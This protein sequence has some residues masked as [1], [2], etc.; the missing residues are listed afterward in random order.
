MDG[1]VVFCFPHAGGGSHQYLSWQ[2]EFPDGMRWVAIDRAG[3]YSRSGELPKERFEHLVKDLVEQLL[4]EIPKGQ[5]ALFGH[6]MGGALAFEV[7]RELESRGFAPTCLFVSSTVAPPDRDEHGFRFF[8]MEDEQFID[9]LLSLSDEGESSNREVL[10][11][12]L[13][14]IRDEY[15]Q[16]HRYNPDRNVI[17]ETP[18]VAL[19]GADEP[20]C[21]SMV[22]WKSFT[23]AFQGVFQFSG[24][25]FYWKKNLIEV[26]ALIS[27]YLNS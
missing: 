25:H 21:A 20:I 2:S 17:L 24:G 16:Y 11:A 7:T 8:D 12:F 23:S 14:D 19:C 10:R 6:S 13:P 22:N 3:R 1:P 18:I 26:A 5:F 27:K 9:H 4:P 15:R